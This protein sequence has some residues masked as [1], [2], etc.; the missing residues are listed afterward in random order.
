L[1]FLT[2][3]KSVQNPNLTSR[4]NSYMTLAMIGGAERD[5]TADL[6]VAKSLRNVLSVS[7]HIF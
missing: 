3:K 1:N 5:R 6:L 7:Y 4:Q 2:E